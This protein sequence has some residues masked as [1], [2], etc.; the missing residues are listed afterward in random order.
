VL[1]Q[2]LQPLL[3]APLNVTGEAE[4]ELASAWHQLHPAGI[5]PAQL[6]ELPSGCRQSRLLL[7]EQRLLSLDG[8]QGLAQ[9]QLSFGAGSSGHGSTLPRSSCLEKGCQPG[10]VLSDSK[11]S[12]RGSWRALARVLAWVVQPLLQ[13]SPALT[14]QQLGSRFGR[15]LFGLGDM[16]PE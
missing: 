6:I 2:Q 5:A 9:L 14:N 7:F 16:G 11:L 13:S 8:C 15:L 3:L 4:L 12:N 10:T 1:G